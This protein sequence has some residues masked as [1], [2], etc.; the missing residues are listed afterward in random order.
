MTKFNLQN[1]K[2]LISGVFH[3]SKPA[4]KIYVSLA[5]TAGTVVVPVLGLA[6]EKPIAE[7]NGTSLIENVRN[8]PQ[9][10]KANYIMY[11]VLALLISVIYTIST[12]DKSQEYEAAKY[13]I[14]RKLRELSAKNPVLKNMTDD[15]TIYQIGDLLASYMD[16]NDRKNIES[17]ACDFAQNSREAEFFGDTQMKTGA[18]IVAL[19]QIED[20]INRIFALNP[21]LQD[22][23][24]QIATGKSLYNPNA[25]AKKQAKEYQG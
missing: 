21:E 18:K 2:T 7:A 10:K 16:K 8:M 1:L 24:I 20:V 13:I 9:A 5:L 25:F 6:E 12:L 15:E 17:S 23:V 22:L 14:K 4:K 3:K 11:W 19:K